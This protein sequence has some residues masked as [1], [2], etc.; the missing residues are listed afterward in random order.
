MLEKHLDLTREL[1]RQVTHRVIEGERN[2]CTHE[3]MDTWDKKTRTLTELVGNVLSSLS[4]HRKKVAEQDLMGRCTQATLITDTPVKQPDHDTQRTDTVSG[5]VRCQLPL[6][7]SSNVSVYEP[8]GGI[9]GSEAGTAGT[10][11]PL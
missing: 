3:Y 2:R 4:P 11:D 8:Q 5:E 9:S 10:D 1:N 6:A 7:V